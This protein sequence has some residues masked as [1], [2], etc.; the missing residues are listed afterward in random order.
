MRECMSCANTDRPGNIKDL[1]SKDAGVCVN[2]LPEIKISE[3]RTSQAFLIENLPRLRR[4]MR[5][6]R[7]YLVRDRSA[8]VNWTGMID[9]DDGHG[10]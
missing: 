6:I 5:C 1:I 9:K 4:G 2:V 10:R 3:S 8:Q 7:P